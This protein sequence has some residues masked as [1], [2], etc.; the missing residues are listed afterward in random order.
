[1]RALLLPLLS[2]AL[3]CQTRIERLP[4]GSHEIAPAYSQP[5]RAWE[6][7]KDARVVGVIV[8][9]DGGDHRRRFYSVRNAWHQELGLVDAAGRAWRYRPHEREA[10]WL[11]TGTVV[12]GAARV[13]G[14]DGEIELFDVRVG[15][16]REEN[17][18]DDPSLRG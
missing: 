18:R 9:F 17:D 10:D 15:A 16:L 14:V 2:L 11:G 7:V 13:L 3:G 6:L 5:L 4:A 12:E 1:M 8:E